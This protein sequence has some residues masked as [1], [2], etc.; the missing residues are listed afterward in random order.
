MFGGSGSLNGGVVGSQS[1]G[2]N[3]KLVLPPGKYVAEANATFVNTFASSLDANCDLRFDRSG[4][5]IFIDFL[6]LTLGGIGEPAQWQTAH[7]AGAFEL[8]AGDGPLRVSCLANTDIDYEDFDM[9]ATRVETLTQA[10]AP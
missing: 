9:F 4:T 7:L 8:L 1:T 2:A 6:D 5:P 3:S 10:G